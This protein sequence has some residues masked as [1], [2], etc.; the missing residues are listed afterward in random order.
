MD[1][2]PINSTIISEAAHLHV[3]KW[4]RSLSPC[5]RWA[6]WSR[7]PVCGFLEQAAGSDVGPAL[8]R[9]VIWDMGSLESTVEVREGMRMG[10][11]PQGN[12]GR[13]AWAE[14]RGPSSPRVLI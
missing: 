14:G 9:E 11:S 3:R 7:N 1:I 2:E 13:R 10:E 5:P 4:A 12:G 8:W 6:R